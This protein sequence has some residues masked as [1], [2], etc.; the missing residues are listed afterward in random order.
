MNYRGKL[1]IGG[2]VLLLAFGVRPEAGA[3]T[4]TTPPKVD[5]ITPTTARI[6]WA[7][8]V[9]SSTLIKYGPTPALEYSINGGNQSSSVIVHGWFLGGLQPDTDYYFQVCSTADSQQ[10]CSATQTFRTLPRPERW[11]EEPLLPQQEVDTKYP[12]QTGN[13]LQVGAD[14]NDP[15][16]GLM[17]RWNQAQWGDTITIPPGT[18]CIGHY[19]FTAKTPDTQTPH[20]WIV[21]RT[22]ANDNELPPEG[23][24]I[25][26]EYKQVMATIASNQPR[27]PDQALSEGDANCMAGDYRWNT[28]DSRPFKLWKCVNGPTRAITQV[29]GNNVSPIVVTMPGHGYSSG[30]WVRISGV[31]GNTAANGTWSITVQDSDTFTLNYP[32]SSWVATRGNGDYTGG[33]EAGR[34]RWTPVP[35]QSGATLPST[36]TPGEWFVKDGTQDLRKYR[37]YWCL[38]PNSWTQVA[39][40]YSIGSFSQQAAIDLTQSEVSYVRFV[41]LEITSIR[42]PEDPLHEQYGANRSLYMFEALFSAGMRNHHIILDR[43]YIHPQIETAG[44]ANGV[45]TAGAHF[46][47]VDSYLD[48]MTRYGGNEPDSNAGEAQAVYFTVGPGPFKLENNYFQGPGITVFMQDENSFN[49]P[50]AWLPSDITIR[51]NHFRW[52]P[53]W[54]YDPDDP[55]SI[56][57]L[58]VIPRHLLEFKIGQRILIEGNIFENTWTKINNA[59]A[60]MLSPR[61]TGSIRGRGQISGNRFT[62]YYNKP[63]YEFDPCDSVVV[64]EWVAIN[65]GDAP[66]LRGLYQVSAKINSTSFELAGMSGSS[67]DAYFMR[68]QGDYTI[69]DVTIR[70]NV[71]RNVANGIWVMGRTD[72]NLVNKTFQRLKIE[73]NLF[74]SVSFLGDKQPAVSSFPNGFGGGHTLR[75]DLGMESVIFMHNTTTMPGIY[76]L[77]I[78]DL[79]SNA[80]LKYEN[81]IVFMGN[82]NGQDAIGRTGVYFGQA[83]LDVGFREGSQPSW[84]YRKN[85]IA[86]A[87]PL[88]T[89]PPYG[90]YPAGNLHHDLSQEPFPFVNAAEKD[91]RLTRYRRGDNCFGQP[92]DCTTTGADMGADI[93]A[94][95]EALG[96][97]QQARITTTGSEEIGVAFLAPNPELSCGVEYIAPGSSQATRIPAAA[98]G[99]L[100]R[101]TISGLAPGTTYQVRVLCGTVEQLRPTRTASVGGS[102]ALAIKLTPPTGLNVV[103]ARLLAGLNPQQLTEADSAPCSAGCTLTATGQAG[104]V[105]YFR[106]EYTLA[107]GQKHQSGLNSKVP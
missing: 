51:R 8:D 82:V 93:N 91:F 33:G 71:F 20:R 39:L 90:P 31:T 9:P 97:V 35:Y 52:D 17:A 34:N 101:A 14:C 81:N 16:T 105:L 107:N 53:K 23:T 86:R 60:I 55:V 75:V 2:A 58:G 13:V 62:C 96:G 50:D 65:S 54:R 24:R 26:P 85:V 15:E 102:A 68:V 32:W 6:V 21:I 100:R 22:A 99:R 3:V 61:L 64:G 47:I 10:A 41:G 11:P 12:L 59:A 28:N 80:A 74:E 95:N 27:F 5:G 69:R 4:I 38:A 70:K 45:Q 79:G 103:S 57:K 18:Q 76:S 88:P 7:T 87:G 56:K 66:S 48:E 25:T 37:A 63:Y 42:P 43:C 94:L 36:C 106:Y 44:T 67:S 77:G 92:G 19:V 1:G 46:A 89:S 72:Y 29:S 73:G 104:K 30:N 84:S 98:D 78:G 83:A 40:E 49:L